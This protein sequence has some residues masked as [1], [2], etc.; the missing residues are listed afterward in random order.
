M[1]RYIAIR[2]VT[3]T[4]CPNVGTI[5]TLSTD[6]KFKEAIEQHFD[7]ELITY[8]FVDKEITSLL[9]C[10]DSYPITITVTL[11]LGYEHS[12]YLVELSET[13]LY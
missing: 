6:R 12:E 2:E 11:D 4:E 8:S 1:I 3:N 10:I 5:T 9:D 7:A 13:W